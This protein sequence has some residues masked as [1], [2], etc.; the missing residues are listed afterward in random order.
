M[1]RCTQKSGPSFAASGLHISCIAASFLAVRPIKS[2]P[3]V[4]N[5]SR[6]ANARRSSSQDSTRPLP[7]IPYSFGPK[8]CSPSSRQTSF[9]RVRSHIIL[10]DF[11]KTL[12]NKGGNLTVPLELILKS[13]FDV[14]PMTGA[15]SIFASS[16]RNKSGMLRQSLLQMLFKSEAKSTGNL[17]S[18]IVSPTQGVE[19][20]PSCMLY[21]CN[22]QDGRI[23]APPVK[24]KDC[25]LIK[26]VLPTV[27]HAD[28]NSGSFAAAAAAAAAC[29]L[30]PPFFQAPLSMSEC[31]FDATNV[32]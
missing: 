17:F 20:L 15:T 3:V 5:I 11:P 23:C 28:W 6:G 30:K 4:C 22:W 10:V 29:I 32:F 26:F 19:M 18:S 8:P 31:P 14:P 21:A 24:R 1:S 2:G 12:T 7:K 9:S 25:E 16:A 13:A 27:G